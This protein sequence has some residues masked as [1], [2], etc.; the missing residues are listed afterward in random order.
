MMIS[1]V[2]LAMPATIY[3]RG[4]D[5]IRLCQPQ[6][7]HHSFYPNK[8]CSPGSPAVS[9]SALLW[10]AQIMEGWS[11]CWPARPT[12]PL[13]FIV[14]SWESV[15]SRPSWYS[16][17]V[18]GQAD[19]LFRGS[20]HNYSSS[21]PKVA[22]NSG[23]PIR[24]LLHVPVRALFARYL[25]WLL[26]F[27][28]VCHLQFSPWGPPTE[29]PRTAAQEGKYRVDENNK[30]G[31]INLNL[32]R[33][34]HDFCSQHS[35]KKHA[36]ID[37]EFEWLVKECSIQEVSMTVW[38]AFATLDNK[39][40]LLGI[41]GDEDSK[42]ATDFLNFIVHSINLALDLKNISWWSWWKRRRR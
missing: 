19:Q 42:A 1:T 3:P 37:A 29:P 8:D 39:L 36:M 25:P 18:H 41:S 21:P 33:Q 24:Q 10:P 23:A 12:P 35:C 30:P 17:C 4:T 34:C 6:L 16:V 27:A 20:K 31:R 13:R 32:A 5:R 22:R 7:A 26:D 11:S 15:A 38:A 40:T 9:L 14:E 2:F 28:Q